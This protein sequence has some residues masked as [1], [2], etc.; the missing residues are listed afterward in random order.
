MHCVVSVCCNP[1]LL[2]GV[3]RLCVLLLQA[4]AWG[5]GKQHFVGSF[6]SEMDAAR[7]YDKVR[8][9]Y[10]DSAVWLLSQCVTAAG[11]DSN[12]AVGP[13]GGC[14]RPSNSWEVLALEFAVQ[15]AALHVSV[16]SCA[17]LA[18]TLLNCLPFCGSCVQAI[19]KLGAMQV[20]TALCA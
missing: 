7:S 16:S 3:L 8:C 4:R 14:I 6:K 15:P 17:V 9:R 13:T 2:L 11:P 12:S 20:S 19:L 1:A 10:M 5:G 18:V